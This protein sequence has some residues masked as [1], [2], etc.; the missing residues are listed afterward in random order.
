MET[1]CATGIRVS[2]LRHITVEAVQR[3]TA[4]K[5]RP[6]IMEVFPNS[7]WTFFV[8]VESA[9]KLLELL[10]V[11]YNFH[12]FLLAD[13]FKQIHKKAALRAYAP[14]RLLGVPIAC[15]VRTAEKP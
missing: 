3:G 10:G 11:K 6:H 15:S 4:K 1:I 7:R 5:K 8:R 2:E 9:A 14:G 12:K 13:V